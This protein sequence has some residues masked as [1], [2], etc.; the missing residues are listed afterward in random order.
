ME[1]Y[2]GGAGNTFFGKVLLPEPV[3]Q[4]FLYLSPLIFTAESFQL[5]FLC[6]QHQFGLF[7]A[8]G[9]L[10]KV[11]VTSDRIVKLNLSWSLYLLQETPY[12]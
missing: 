3:K 7:V 5:F 8:S 2:L 9:R 4:T 10:E 12:L 1:H 6:I 11:E